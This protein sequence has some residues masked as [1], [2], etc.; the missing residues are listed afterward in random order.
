MRGVGNISKKPGLVVNELFHKQNRK[1]MK[2]SGHRH[3]KNDLTSELENCL[4]EYKSG[5][6]FSMFMC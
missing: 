5:F 3:R 2:R 4:H 6:L 1:F